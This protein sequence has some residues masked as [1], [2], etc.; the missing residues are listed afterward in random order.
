[1]ANEVKVK[2]GAQHTFADHL[3]DFT[4][5]TA[6][7]SL[8]ITGGASDVQ[9]DLTSLAD[10]TGRESAKLDLGATRADKFSVMASF[11]FAA[12]P[13][14][15]EV[16]ELYWAP[17]PISAAGNGNPMNIDGVDV[18]APSG[19]GTLQE[20][21]DAC[22]YIGAFVVTDDITTTVQTAYVG[23]FSPAERYGILIVKNESGAAFHSDAAEHHV[24]F[25]EI[26]TEIQ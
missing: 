17:S 12:T 10:T 22:Q 6:K 24:T 1:M 13:T 5:G 19:L 9:I 21:V 4:G 23:T 11:E 20:L 16:V 3:T 2:V 25:T 7:S 14:V 18:N 15:G 8:E 26:L